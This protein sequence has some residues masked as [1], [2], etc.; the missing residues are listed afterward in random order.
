[1]KSLPRGD[2][3]RIRAYPLPRAARAAMDNAATRVSPHRGEQRVG[4]PRRP[5]L[6]HRA[7]LRF[8]RFSALSSS[9]DNEYNEVASS[10]AATDRKSCLTPSTDSLRAM[11][12]DRFV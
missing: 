10:T 2:R 3:R 6:V 9:D 8:D 5:T 7:L 4:L 12:R 11:H 1:M